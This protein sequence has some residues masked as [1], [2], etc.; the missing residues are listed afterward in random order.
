MGFIVKISG[1]I[2]YK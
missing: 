2:C 1:K